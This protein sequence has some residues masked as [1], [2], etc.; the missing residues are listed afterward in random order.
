LAHEIAH[1]VLHAIPEND[2]LMEG[3]ADN[4]ASN[5]LMPASD[6]R[7]QL[8]N[9]TLEKLARL[10]SYWK[11]SMQ[12][13]LLRAMQLKTITKWQAEYL[14]RQIAKSGYRLREPVGIP[15]EEPSMLS[16]LINSYMGEL[17]FSAAELAAMLHVRL[18]EFSELYLGQRLGLAVVAA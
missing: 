18:S 7:H 11:V 6:I 9:L 2:E 10:K 3:Q 4:F 1:L 14:W 16:R 12:A 15:K 17:K 13:L 5:F 8:V